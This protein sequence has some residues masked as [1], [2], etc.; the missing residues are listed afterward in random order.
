MQ[1][2]VAHNH[3]HPPRSMILYPLLHT[4]SLVEVSGHISEMETYRPTTVA[5]KGH[6]KL[7]ISRFPILE[8]RFWKSLTNTEQKSRNRK[9]GMALLS[10]RIPQDFL[11]WPRRAMSILPISTFSITKSSHYQLLIRIFL[12][13]LQMPYIIQTYGKIAH[14]QEFYKISNSSQKSQ[15]LHDD[16]YD[17]QH[18]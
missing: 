8:M 1:Y 9:F 7:Q 17:H 15:T 6:S 10:H 14:F 16:Y 13:F 3:P 2:V 18:C 5:E 12:I 11:L 4:Y